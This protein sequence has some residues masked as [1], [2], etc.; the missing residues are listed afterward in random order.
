[1]NMEGVTRHSSGLM[2]IGDAALLIIL[3][4]RGRLVECNGLC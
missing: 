3:E 2:R 1:M 4:N